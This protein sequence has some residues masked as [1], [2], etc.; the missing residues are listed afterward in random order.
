MCD[1][2]QLLGVRPKMNR[3]PAARQIMRE[4]FAEDSSF[5]EGYV[6]N[7]AMYIYAQDGISLQRANE[8]ANEI[9]KICF[10]EDTNV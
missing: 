6:A 3:V 10:Y 4:A 9:L 5:W 8:I 2:D 1:L 7:I